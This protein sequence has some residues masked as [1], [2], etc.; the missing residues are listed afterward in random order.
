[1]RYCNRL[2]TLLLLTFLF[3][4]RCAARDVLD[5]KSQHVAESGYDFELEIKP[6]PR[7]FF[8]MHS[9]LHFLVSQ[10][11]DKYVLAMLELSQFFSF[12]VL[13]ID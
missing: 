8:E 10:I 3:K 11:R 5:G 9:L 7:F 4:L 2:K 6:M 1:M 12:F 13:L